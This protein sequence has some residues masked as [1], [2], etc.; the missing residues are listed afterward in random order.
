MCVCVRERVC[1]IGVYV[2]SDWDRF[3]APKPTC[4]HETEIR[5]RGYLKQRLL[6]EGMDG[7]RE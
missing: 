6:A 2:D 1:E 4:Q 3:L 7:G 5:K